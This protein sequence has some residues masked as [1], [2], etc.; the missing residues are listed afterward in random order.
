MGNV[1]RANHWLHGWTNQPTDRSVPPPLL[2]SHPE[3]HSVVV[4]EGAGTHSP[5]AALSTGSGIAGTGRGRK[6]GALPQSVIAG[7]GGVVAQRL[8]FTLKF[9]KR[10]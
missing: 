8:G 1:I 5:P 9:G 7:G 3:M 10:E 2:L 6:S 4:S